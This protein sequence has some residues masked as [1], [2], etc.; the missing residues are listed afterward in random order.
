MEL[1]HIFVFASVLELLMPSLLTRTTQ[2]PTLHTNTHRK[3]RTRY[4]QNTTVPTTTICK[5][6]NDNKIAFP[7]TLLRLCT[8]LED[9]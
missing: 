8:R 7:A 2:T 4:Q 1:C 5:L 3:E 9:P 6:G